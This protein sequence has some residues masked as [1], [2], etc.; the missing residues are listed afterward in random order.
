MTTDASVNE[1]S[2]LG[3]QENGRQNLVDNTERK[4]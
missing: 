3:N 1:C 2:P 4:F